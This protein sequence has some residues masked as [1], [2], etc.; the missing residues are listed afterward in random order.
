M[1][2]NLVQSVASTILDYRET[3]SMLIL[4]H[5]EFIRILSQLLKVELE[6][7]SEVEIVKSMKTKR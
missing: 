1:R 5:L 2:D 7:I 4:L 3:L 6:E